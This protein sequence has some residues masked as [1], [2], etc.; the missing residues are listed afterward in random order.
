[1]Q[2]TITARH[3]D[4]TNAIR[5][6]VEEACE[7]LDRYFEH[8]TNVHFILTYENNRNFAEMSLH[9]GHFNLQCQTEENDMY[10]AIDNAIEKMEGQVK[11]LKERVTDH[12]KK[13]LKDQ[14][15]TVRA[16]MYARG[17]QKGDKRRIKTKKI[18]AEAMDIDDALER[19]TTSEDSYY[20]FRN[21]ETDRINVLVKK[22]NDHFKLLEP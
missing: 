5:D 1:M 15:D 7:K 3:F 13:G 17:S 6:Y 8:I 10:M 4:L 20:I 11:K 12:Q 19:L 16:S 21:V 22:D 2:I 9:A 18:M 14:Y